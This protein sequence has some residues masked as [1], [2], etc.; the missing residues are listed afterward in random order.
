MWRCQREKL[1][2]DAIPCCGNKECEKIWLDT[3]P[4]GFDLY[5]TWSEIDYEH[6]FDANI[7]EGLN[8][9]SVFAQGAG[10]YTY[11]SI[12]GVGSSIGTD[13]WGY[14]PTYYYPYNIKKISP[15]AYL[16]LGGYIVPVNACQSIYFTSR[17]HGSYCNRHF[18]IKLDDVGPD[19]K[20]WIDGVPRRFTLRNMEYTCTWRQNLYYH[21]PNICTESSCI[22]N[23]PMN[24]AKSVCSQPY[25]YRTVNYTKY[26]VVNGVQQQEQVSEKIP[27]VC[28]ITTKSYNGSATL[29][30]TVITCD[31]P[32]TFEVKSD[33]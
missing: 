30:Q 4:N 14:Y 20:H 24:L 2:E 11:F 33:L 31:V 29:K 12:N 22:N 28:S 19:G 25:S 7:T 9:M 8:Y 16:N 17:L 10:G 27:N 6:H 3:L 21:L 18:Y 23:M 26:T 13:G 15:Y 32:A 1:K 5:I